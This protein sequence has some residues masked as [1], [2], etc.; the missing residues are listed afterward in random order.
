M[1]HYSEKKLFVLYKNCRK[2]IENRPDRRQRAI[3]KI[4]EIEKE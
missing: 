2:T 1:E 3:D 4:A